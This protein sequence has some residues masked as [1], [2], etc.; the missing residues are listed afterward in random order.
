MILFESSYSWFWQSP[1]G[2]R[3]IP[4]DELQ[5]STDSPLHR[6]LIASLSLSP[7]LGGTPQRRLALPAPISTNVGTGAGK[8][9]I[10][11]PSSSTYGWGG[12]GGFTADEINLLFFFLHHSQLWGFF[13]CGDSDT[14]GNTGCEKRGR[15]LLLRSLPA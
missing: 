5:S 8:R 7:S 15:D 13:F 6:R 3:V 4:S 12:G 1:N 9:C 11:S 10:Q 2:G 14:G